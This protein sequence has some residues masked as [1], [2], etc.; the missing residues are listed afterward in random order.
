M[1]LLTQVN[2]RNDGNFYFATPHPVIQTAGIGAVGTLT[3][4]TALVFQNTNITFNTGVYYVQAQINISNITTTA[5]DILTLALI[6]SL[7][8][9]AASVIATF[10]PATITNAETGI[11]LLSGYINTQSDNGVLQIKASGVIQSGGSY[12]ITN[13]TSSKIFVQ[14]VA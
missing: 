11:V 9:D 2:E 4:S 1:S 8:T 13:P 5:G 14:Q 12:T 6:Q 3:P 7:S 10:N